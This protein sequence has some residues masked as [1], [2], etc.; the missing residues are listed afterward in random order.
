MPLAT[1][2]PEEGGRCAAAAAAAAAN[3]L[4]VHAARPYTERATHTPHESCPL[5]GAMP[6]RLLAAGTATEIRLDR[7]RTLERPLTDPPV[8]LVLHDALIDLER[9]VCSS[10]LLSATENADDEPTRHH[11]HLP[12]NDS[13]SNTGTRRA[14]ARARS[15]LLGVNTGSHAHAYLLPGLGRDPPGG[16]RAVRVADGPGGADHLRPAVRPPGKERREDAERQLQTELADKAQQLQSMQ[17]AVAVEREERKRLRGRSLAQTE[18]EAAAT[19]AALEAELA[20]AQ[21]ALEA[22]QV[23]RPPAVAAPDQPLPR[24]AAYRASC[25]RLDKAQVQQALESARTGRSHRDLHSATWRVLARG[26][27]AI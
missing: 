20:S 12:F 19:Q 9:R 25:A 16:D 24:G 6:A 2:C 3:H 17:I 11:P 5:V 1:G 15:V 7:G 21:K 22:A 4:L 23:R 8:C 10:G 13:T 26:R 18:E 14:E 27:K